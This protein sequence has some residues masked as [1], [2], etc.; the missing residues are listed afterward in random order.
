MLVSVNYVELSKKKKCRRKECTFFFK[1]DKPKNK[2]KQNKTKKENTTITMQQTSKW[3]TNWPYLQL[4][5][6]LL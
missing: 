4:V 1:F 6:D 5:R 2:T 3:Q